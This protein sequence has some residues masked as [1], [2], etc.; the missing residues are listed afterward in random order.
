MNTYGKS[1]ITGDV[2]VKWSH[3]LKPDDKFGNPNHSITVEV[4]PAL[5]AKLN[6]A[7]KELGAKKINGLKDDTIKFKNVLKIR[8]GINRFPVVD[9][10]TKE[11]DVIPMS[12]DIVRVK[13]TPALV[14]RDNSISFYLDAVQ[15]IKK[16][17]PEYS[18]NNGFAPV[19]VPDSD[20]E[21]NNPF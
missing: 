10:A 15:L 7:L 5:K 12:E 21:E 4:T 13:V 14:S 3:L 6:A 19:A 1:F 9:A 20:E 18:G 17:S 16:N 2:T 11:T 8:D